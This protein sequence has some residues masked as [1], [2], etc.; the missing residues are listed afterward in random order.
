M[1]EKNTRTEYCNNKTARCIL[2]REAAHNFNP[3]L[4]LQFNGLLTNKAHRRRLMRL[5]QGIIEALADAEDEK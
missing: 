3:R 2:T 5:A 4:Y 1:I